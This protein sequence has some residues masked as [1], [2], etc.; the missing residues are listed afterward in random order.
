MI[1]SLISSKGDGASHGWLMALRTGPRALNS[2][3]TRLE[4]L[5]EAKGF[6]ANEKHRL[7]GRRRSGGGPTTRLISRRGITGT[8]STH[9]PSADECSDQPLFARVHLLAL[10]PYGCSTNH[11]GT[12]ML[13]SAGAHNGGALSSGGAE[14]SSTRALPSLTG[15]VLPS[16]YEGPFSIV[17]LAVPPDAGTNWILMLICSVSTWIV[18]VFE[19][20]RLMLAVYLKVTST[21]YM[22]PGVKVKGLTLAVIPSLLRRSS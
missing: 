13:C 19:A 14:I 18:K 1:C 16:A 20:L 22:Y 7:K 21:V 4:F 15:G 11:S 17:R 5:E 9:L 2:Q 6:I 3:D 10:R 8:S 12:P